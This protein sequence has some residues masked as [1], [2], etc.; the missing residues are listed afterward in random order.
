VVTD[1]RTYLALV[2]MLIALATGIV[3]FTVVVTGLSLSVG[4]AI[5]IVGVP[6][7][8]AFLAV[9][10]ALA[11]V[12]GR[13]VEVL[14]G[15]RMPRRPRFGPRE[16][17]FVQ[18]IL[19]WLKDRRTW[20]AML[21]MVLQLPLGVIY[22]TLAVTGLATGVGLVCLPV[23]ELATGRSF[24]LLGDAE[25]VF[26]SWLFPLPVLAGGML[27]LLTLHLVRL[28]GKAH[29]SYAKAM[30]VRPAQQLSG[31]TMVAV[32]TSSTNTPSVN[33]V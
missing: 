3:Y 10:R 9:V 26:A 23:V 2:Y 15:V 17:G 5:L 27:F 4:L 29:G 19:Y 30:L 33:G 11:L 16:G 12:E 14:L 20:T 7:S 18:R 28:I 31:P 24:T 32:P 1:S 6:F 22:F 25:G 13:L 21:Y 8:L